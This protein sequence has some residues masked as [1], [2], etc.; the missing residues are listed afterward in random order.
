MSVFGDPLWSY[1]KSFQGRRRWV[2]API[3]SGIVLFSHRQN[4]LPLGWFERHH[5]QMKTLHTLAFKKITWPYLV[6]KHNAWILNLHLKSIT[7]QTT[8]RA[9]A[10]EFDILMTAGLYKP[11]AHLL[12][13]R[14]EAARVYR[15][16]PQGRMPVY[17]RILLSSVFLTLSTSQRR[18]GS[19][20]WH[21]FC[22]LFGLLPPNP[23]SVASLSI[24]YRAQ[25]K[26]N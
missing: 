10:S 14:C 13:Q 8:A 15:S 11:A 4:L 18:I 5:N 17:Y 19:W 1:W 21:I 6:K 25:G 2:P 12:F 23:L 3:S 20:F 16:F 24:L 26:H 9:A 22:E 7:H